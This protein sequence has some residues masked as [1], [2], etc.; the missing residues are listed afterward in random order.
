MTAIFR[1]DG[2][3][4]LAAGKNRGYFQSVSEAWRINKVLFM[5]NSKDWLSNIKLRLSYRE[6]GNDRIGNFQMLQSYVFVSTPVL[7][8]TGYIILL[9]KMNDLKTNCQMKSI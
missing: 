8:K 5:L 2:S 6:V 3:S 4:Q 1:A 7:N 9:Y